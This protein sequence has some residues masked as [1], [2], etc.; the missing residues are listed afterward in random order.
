MNL[1]TRAGDAAT[2]LRTATPVDVEDGLRRL[3]RAHQRRTSGKV[4]AALAAVALG[5]GVVQIQSDQDSAVQPASDTARTSDTPTTP[6]QTTDLNPSPGVDFVALETTWFDVSSSGVVWRVSAETCGAVL[7]ARVL[8]QDG[9]GGW[10]TLTVLKHDDATKIRRSDRDH[11][12]VFAVIVADG[13]RDAWVHGRSGV[14][15]THDGGQSWTRQPVGTGVGVVRVVGEYVYALGG[16]RRMFRSSVSSDNWA[17]ITGP[18]VD[19]YESVSA[20][21]DRVVVGGGCGSSRCRFP[22]KYEYFLSDDRGVTWRGLSSPCPSRGVELK[23]TA[24]VLVARCFR[25]PAHGVQTAKYSFYRSFDGLTWSQMAQLEN[26]FLDYW[27]PVDDATVFVDS[28]PRGR[29]LVTGDDQEQLPLVSSF[30]RQAHFVTRDR[31]YVIA[32]IRGQWRL[33]G[34]TDGGST[35]VQLD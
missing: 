11:A 4:T 27:V 28:Y 34:T 10:T 13:D 2:H 6:E 33:L 26:G 8:R 31:G 5:V 29:L 1:E 14:W 23:S 7:C 22:S 19:R 12:P 20:L 35:W 25:D 9:D 21:G 16:G 24:A 32:S 17:P 18:P 30:I 3:R 15:S